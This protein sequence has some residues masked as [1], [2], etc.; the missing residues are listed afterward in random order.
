MHIKLCIPYPVKD[1]CLRALK[2]CG[3]ALTICMLGNSLNVFVIIEADVMFTRRIVL[4]FAF[5]TRYP[6]GL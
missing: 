2:R 4:L 5:W 3:T 6:M 1:P